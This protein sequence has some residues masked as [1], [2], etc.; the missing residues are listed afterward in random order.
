MHSAGERVQ[1]SETQRRFGD[2]LYGLQALQRARNREEWLAA[3]AMIGEQ[4]ASHLLEGLGLLQWDSREFFFDGQ[5][6]IDPYTGLPQIETC[7]N[8]IDA[9]EDE[10]SDL[11]KWLYYDK[12]AAIEAD[13]LMREGEIGQAFWRLLPYAYELDDAAARAIG[14]WPEE[15]RSYLHLYRKTR[16]DRLEFTV[17]NI[18]RVDLSWHRR[19][20]EKVTH[21]TLEGKVSHELGGIFVPVEGLATPAD[22]DQYLLSF[23]DMNSTLVGKLSQARSFISEHCDEIDM[24]AQLY[25]DLAC[26]AQDNH[27]NKGVQKALDQTL[28]LARQLGLPEQ[29]DLMDMAGS[30]TFDPQG[31]D[32]ALRFL[33]NVRRYGVWQY[34]RQLVDGDAISHR[35]DQ[36]DITMYAQRAAR[37]AGVM[38]GCPGGFG[39]E[40]HGGET[41]IGPCGGPCRRKAIVV[42]IGSWCYDC[43]TGPNG[44]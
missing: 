33:I 13:H 14:M 40:W 3:L 31:H 24:I 29:W 1:A 39:M 42:G 7:Q 26:S 6:L 10:P 16:Y 41:H 25:A 12:R 32:T 22:Q 30:K 38:P 17:V 2:E 8:A 4:E 34:M 28:E 15:Q 37:L 35:L 19:L 27:L 5:F 9:T 21:T 18:D 36:T 43:I 11:M 23:L 44:C 20:L